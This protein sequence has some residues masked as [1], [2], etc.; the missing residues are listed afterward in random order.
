M[1]EIVITPT[2]GTLE[3]ACS[4]AYI[5]LS[6]SIVSIGV[7]LYGGA[8]G[9]GAPCLRSIICL[10]CCE[11]GKVVGSVKIYYNG[12]GGFPLMLAVEVGRGAH[13]LDLAP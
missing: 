7:I 3:E 1:A 4:S 13:L 11:G 8:L 10:I 2:K 6:I 12:R 5:C 9:R